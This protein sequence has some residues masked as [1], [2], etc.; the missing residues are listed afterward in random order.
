LYFYITQ[1]KEQDAWAYL[2]QHCKT[3]ANLYSNVHWRLLPAPIAKRSP[4]S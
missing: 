2:V 4:S 1:R 3:A